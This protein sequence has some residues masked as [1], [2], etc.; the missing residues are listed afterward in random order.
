MKQYLSNAKKAIVAILIFWTANVSAQAYSEDFDNGSCNTTFPANWT[1]AST[2]ADWLIDATTTGTCGGGVPTCTVAGSSGGSVLA[3]ADG[4]GGI[5][6]SAVSASINATGYTGLTVDWNG[7]RSTGAPAV[8]LEYSFDDVTYTNVAFSDVASDAQWHA[9]STISLPA[10]CDNAPVLYLRWS[11]TSTVGGGEFIAFDDIIVNGTT[12]KTFYWNGSGA[13]HLLGSWGANPN[14]TG[15]APLSFTAS[16]QTFNIY[17]NTATSFADSL[18]GAW[19]VSGGTVNVNIGNGS[20][21]S[22]QLTIPSGF[23][24]TLSSAT[25]NVNNSSTLTI[26][27]TTFPTAGAVNVLSGSTV[28]FAQAAQVAIWSKTYHNLTLSGGANKSQ[29][30]NPTIN[31]TFN[32]TN[33]SSNYVMSNSSLQTTTING[34]VT[35]TGAMLTGNSKLTIGGTG[36][37][38]TLNFGVGSTNKT[39]NILTLNRTGDLILG[40]DLTVNGSAALTNGTININSKNLTFNAAVTLPATSSNGA[41]VGSTTS[42]LNFSTAGAT[43]GSLFMD[44]TSAST[45]ALSYL[46]YN[47]NGSTLT[48]GNPLEIWN[49]IDPTNGTVNSGSN[50]TLK[51]DATHKGRI[52]IING[53][54]SGSPTVELF[55]SAGKTNWV[56]MCSSG[57]TGKNMSDWNASFAITCASCPDG[58]MVGGV[59]FTSIYTYDETQFIGDEANAAH[60]I[61]ITS[62]VALD[63]K[64]GYWVYLGNGFPNTTAITIPLTGGVNT[65][66]SSGAYVLS[67]STASAATDGWNLISN[68]YPSPISVAN[69]LNAIGSASTQIDQTFYVY[70]SNTDVN[71]PYTAAGSNSIIPHGQAFAVRALVN[72]VSFTPSESWKTANVS[73]IGLLKTNAA[74][75]YFW[76]DFLLDLTSTSFPHPFYSNIYFLFD[77]N[78]TTGFDNGKDAY[79]TSNSVLPGMPIMYSVTNNQKFLRNAL[80]S[81]SGNVTIPFTVNTATAGVFQINPVN[82]NKLPAGACVKLYDIGKAVLHDLK[83]GA[84]TATVS[85][86]VTTPQF[87]LRITLNP[88]TLTSNVNHPYCKSDMNGSVVA[89]G[90]GPGPWNYTWKDA[91]SAVIKT[92]N[93]KTS[94]DTLK[95][96]GV[97]SYKVDV[98]TVGSCDNAS[99]NF[100]LNSTAP[101]PV[102][103]FS[104]NKDTL[105]INGSTQFIFTNNSSNANTYLWNFG[106][107]NGANTQNVSYMYTHAG[108]FNVTLTAISSCGD[109]AKY[110]YQVHAVN[111]P[112]LQ[113]ILSY[114]NQDN[115]IKVGKDNRGIY[116]DLN[117]DKNTKASIS[118]TNI[119]GQ[120]L[121]SP[122]T[123]ETAADRYYLDLNAKEQ[124]VFVIV[125]TGEKRFTQKIFHNQN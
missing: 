2:T 86:N 21:I 22:T 119:L 24:L 83:T 82:L 57:V 111:S 73:N 31:G 20:T 117:F 12:L 10:A 11:Y 80:P 28:D 68:P 15:S 72:G 32:I 97:G 109:S 50:L 93:N 101:L 61:P 27:N 87:E 103:A 71:T 34:T 92:S 41:F 62:L 47:R 35:G 91:S 102:A 16:G 79:F 46:I 81:L 8:T 37:L 4:S 124:I 125:T 121:I 84:Y 108:N 9:V 63:S 76:D 43:S 104:V 33:S 5:L 114:Q 74:S 7:Y 19:S 38:G 123:V 70:N 105:N 59:P 77:A 118:V 29:S 106:D 115:S 94:A 1:T 96:I 107:G 44:Q 42:T 64:V 56:N 14:G 122:M 90:S 17:N 18:T 112:T 52:G 54:F 65:K 66:G 113:G 36:S 58:S 45:R 120:V 6:E 30:G 78:A 60:Y 100:A 3:G 98:N 67:L 48:L 40:T 89:S 51:S 75:A 49:S 39:I 116:V 110:T 95:N 25:L 26:Q 53:T 99:G 85:A 13:L 69:M 88:T 23:A 55:K